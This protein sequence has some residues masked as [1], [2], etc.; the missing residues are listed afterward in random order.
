MVLS[1][2]NGFAIDAY[3]PF[4]CHFLREWEIII[5]DQRNHGWNP[6]SAAG[7][8]TQ[9]QMVDDLEAILRAV[10]AEFGQRKTAGAFHS[11]STTVSLLH[12]LKFGSRWDAFILFDPPLAPPSGHALHDTARDFE[13]ALSIWSRQRARTFH[14]V[15]TLASYF[16]GARRMDAAGWLALPN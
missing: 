14:S 15:D 1:H 12:A 11:L 2:G 7:S 10:E 3:F 13:Y 6:R 8:H 5:F 4:W 16:K 9:S